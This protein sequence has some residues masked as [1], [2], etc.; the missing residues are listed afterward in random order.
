MALAY[1]ELWR[2]EAIFRTAK[3]ILETRPIFHQSA[4]AIAG[5]LFCSFPARLLRTELD[6]RLTTA[7]LIGGPP[8][9][10]GGGA[11]AQA[12]FGEHLLQPDLVDPSRLTA[13]QFIDHFTLVQGKTGGHQR[14]VPAAG[15]RA[16]AGGCVA[17]DAGGRPAS[18]AGGVPG[19]Y[20]WSRIL[21]S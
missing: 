1:R 11:G 15:K 19:T 17:A 7:G 3:S 4:A 8:G 10:H 14:C 9:N 5:H 21:S 12:L 6:E 20:C 18:A 13:Q 16:L 2:V